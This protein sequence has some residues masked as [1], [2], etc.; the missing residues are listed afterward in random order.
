MLRYPLHG[1]ES[2]LS[3]QSPDKLTK[4]AFLNLD[5]V[6]G[7]RFLRFTADAVIHVTR[8]FLKDID[9]CRWVQGDVIAG[10]P[11]NIIYQLLQNIRRCRRVR[12]ENLT[13]LRMFCKLTQDGRRL[14]DAG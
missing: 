12:G 9:G 11:V 4:H 8:E 13:E 14:F 3:N 2:F 7:E 5:L 6:L 10:D 1:F